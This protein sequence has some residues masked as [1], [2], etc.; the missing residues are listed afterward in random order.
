MK[1]NI[2]DHIGGNYQEFAEKSKSGKLP[3]IPKIVKDT[4]INSDR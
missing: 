3:K 2:C 4:P 1:L